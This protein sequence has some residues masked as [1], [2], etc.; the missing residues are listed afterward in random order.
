[1]L[2]ILKQSD[3]RISWVTLVL[4]FCLGSLVISPLPSIVDTSARSIDGI[5]LENSSSFD[6]LQSDDD[7]S[8][9]SVRDLIP[10]ELIV[11]RLRSIRLAFQSAFLSLDS[12]PP[13]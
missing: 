6:E 10:G 1:M 3:A 5:D 8:V 4:C 2:H 7:F 12:P 11:S 9:P 13:K